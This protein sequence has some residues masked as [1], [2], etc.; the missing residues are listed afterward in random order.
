MEVGTKLQ[1]KKLNTVL[2]YR[3]YDANLLRVA[4]NMGEEIGE[5]LCDYF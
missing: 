1:Q 5:N 4:N 2:Q 3:E